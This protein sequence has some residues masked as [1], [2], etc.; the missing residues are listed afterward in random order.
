MTTRDTAFAPGTPCWVDLTAP[1][2]DAS[3]AFYGEVFGWQFEDTAPE[4]G[5]YVN[6]TS[7]GHRVAGITPRMPEM[8]GPDVW[9]TYISSADAEA[10]AAA[11]TAAGGT[12]LMPAM[13]VGEIGSMAMAADPAGAVFG[14]WQPGSHLGFA[15]YNEPGSVTWDEN[16]SKDFAATTP[17]Y[18]TVFGWTMD[19]T[20]DTDQFRYYQGQVD[21]NTVVGLM[22]S[23]N[24]LPAEVPS[25][26]AVYFSVPDAD[27]AAA[28]ITRLG[29]TVVSGPEDTPFGRVADVTD[30]AG[31]P[32]K[33]H[34]EKLASPQ[35]G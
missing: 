16:H 10:T 21:G 11:V 1:D 7:D 5:G 14:I 33:L 25:H 20:S 19:K 31:V 2:V 23:A 17:F 15:K 30:N 26:W 6:A 34:S 3:K 12:V 13:A 29:G 24:S 9:T 8:Q 35:S 27:E 18:E 28:T 4:Y 32:F 22:D